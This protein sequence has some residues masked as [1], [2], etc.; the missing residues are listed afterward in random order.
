MI[1]LVTPFAA[2][3]QCAESLEQATGLTAHW[4]ETLQAASTRL[5]SQAYLTVVLDQFLMETEPGHTDVVLE[6][7]GTAM[8][9]QVSFGVSSMGRLVR[10][11][12]SALH[13]R[14]REEGAARR[15][16]ESQMRSELGESLTAVLLSC[17]M[18]L[19]VPGI[20]AVA[21]DKIRMI[22]GLAREMCGRLGAA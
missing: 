17:E 19:A 1:L 11:V 22:D 6:H 2:G 14:A 3:R 21:T 8:L 4:A 18:A 5:R 10:E 20:P 13:R 15:A 16:V 9:L 7:T 12:Q